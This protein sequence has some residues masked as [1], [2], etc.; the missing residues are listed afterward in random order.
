MINYNEEN[1]KNIFK[2]GTYALSGRYRPGFAHLRLSYR[3]VLK[4]TRRKTFSFKASYEAK[5]LANRNE[6]LYS[7]TRK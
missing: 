2:H 4:R 6:R 5:R 7:K 1:K 3:D